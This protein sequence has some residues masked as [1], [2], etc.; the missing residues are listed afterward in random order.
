M[1]LEEV[2]DLKP[3]P[4]EVVV[5][6]RAIGVNPVDSYVRSGL[7]AAKPPLPYTPGMDAA[8]LIDY[9]GEG[10]DN[11]VV[12]ARVYVA[13]TLSGAYAEQALCKKSQVHRLPANVSFDEGAAIGVPGGIA[14]R[15][16]FQKARA[17]PGE[18]VLVHG[19]S[20]GVG[21]VAVQ[22]AR[23]AGLTVIGTAGT[24]KGRELVLKQGAHHAVDHR[25]EGYLE[26]IMDLTGKKGVDVI[27][28]L[29]ANVNLGKDLKIVGHG[30]RVVVIGSRGTVEIDPRDAMGK[31]A[32]I[33]G[34]V[35]FNA[36]ERDY[37]SMHAGLVAALEN[38]T[39]KPVIG[40]QIPLEDAARSHE[41]L[42]EPG[43]YGKIILVP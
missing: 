25:A 40:H 41:A 6:M 8:G 7:Y 12:G 34:V 10:V 14:F 39:L 21:T 36:S 24:E 22:L 23:A 30:G 37:A 43:A 9:V 15:A 29:L 19:A 17:I 13:G 2:P 16:L 27:L 32:S 18:T 3:G 4:G 1:R 20:G 31:D 38:G 26:R 5:R 33:I 11:V 42:M 28:E 35:L